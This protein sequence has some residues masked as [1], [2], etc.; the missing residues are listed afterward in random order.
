MITKTDRSDLRHRNKLQDGKQRCTTADTWA[1]DTRAD[2]SGNQQARGRAG[3]NARVLAAE[4][5]MWERS[6]AGVKA[7]RDVDLAVA[8]AYASQQYLDLHFATILRG[9]VCFILLPSSLKP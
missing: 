3:G 2:G 5:T 8:K 4:G 7:K 1:A 9:E 6:P